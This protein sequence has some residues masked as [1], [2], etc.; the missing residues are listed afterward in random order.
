MGGRRGRRVSVGGQHVGAVRYVP[1]GG[2]GTWMGSVCAPGVSSCV[3]ACR[4]STGTAGACW[5][6]CALCGA[7]AKPEVGC[8]VHRC[9]LGRVGEG[10]GCVGKGCMGVGHGLGGVCGQHRTEKTATPPHLCLAVTPLTVSTASHPLLISAFALRHA[11]P[12]LN[13]LPPS[14]MHP[15]HPSCAPA[16]ATT[17]H[18]PLRLSMDLYPWVWVTYPRV[19]TVAKSYPHPQVK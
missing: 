19:L 6:A 18:V 15:T 7:W 2:G 14:Q 17:T 11:W 3:G 5:R 4:G 8:R 1:W 9:G 13:V 16:P 12:L 10:R